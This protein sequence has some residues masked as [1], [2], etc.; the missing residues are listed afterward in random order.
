[1][2]KKIILVLSV[3]IIGTLLIIGTIKFLPF[4]LPFIQHV[5]KNISQT[6]IKTQSHTKEITTEQELNTALNSSKQKVIKFYASWCGACSYVDSY[7]QE[8]AQELPNISFYSINVDNQELMKKIDELHLSKKGIEY[9]PTFLFINDKK[10]TEFTGA[11]KK[12]E[13][14]SIIKDTFGS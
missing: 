7:Y 13:M 12:E 9:L 3:G 4:K 6:N 8:L 10:T 14:L 11:K 2:N 1:M 5:N